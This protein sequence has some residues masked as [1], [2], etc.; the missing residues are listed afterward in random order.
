MASG[1][2]F[3]QPCFN[4][5]AKDTYQEF[6]RF[7]QHVEFTF[8]GPL[9]KSN[10]KDC[11]GWL[12]M[13]IG[14]QGREVYKTFT[15]DEGQEEDPAEILGKFEN[16]VKPA[17]NKRVARFKAHQRKHNEGEKF[18][19]FVKD[20]RLL[21]LDCDYTNSDDILIDLIERGVRHQKVQERLLDLGQDLT[22]EKAIDKGRQYEFSQSHMTVIRGEEVSRV[23]VKQ[24]D[25]KPKTVKNDK[26]TS[27]RNKHSTTGAQPS[28]YKTINSWKCGKTHETGKC[29]AKGTTCKYCKKPDHW[30]KV[31]RKR[32]SKI[33]IVQDSDNNES[34]DDQSDNEIL[35]IK[36]TEPINHI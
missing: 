34:Q 28:T 22:L 18:D 15:W 24:K 11:A 3:E 7:K 35:Y 8:K 20:L 32:L 17:K 4:W 9:A 10:K 33:N 14:Q 29:P 27:S 1:F 30:L 25:T 16:Y 23:D 31:C 13:W 19:H 2:S 5:D 21:L 36:K 6:Q 26:N 12:G